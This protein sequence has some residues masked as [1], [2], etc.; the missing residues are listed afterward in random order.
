[1]IA[2]NS[3]LQLLKAYEAEIMSAGLVIV[4]SHRLPF[5]VGVSR[6][7]FRSSR[8]QND[9]SSATTATSP[10]YAVPQFIPAYTA[11]GAIIAKSGC[12]RT[13]KNGQM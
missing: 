1:M 5:P 8:T 4:P 10:T 13:E 7:N 9:A 3:W 2:S 6:N 11:L 12:C